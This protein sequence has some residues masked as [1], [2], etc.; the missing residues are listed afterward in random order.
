MGAA[1]VVDIDPAVRDLW[2]PVAALEELRPGWTM[3]TQLL[4]QHLQQAQ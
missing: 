3:R 4:D 2:H 1:P